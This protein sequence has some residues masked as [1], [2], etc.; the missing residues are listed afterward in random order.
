MPEPGSKPVSLGVLLGEAGEHVV[1]D[2]LPQ[3][4]SRDEAEAR[5]EASGVRRPYC[6]SIV[7]NR[8]LYAALARRLRAAGLLNF[9]G[10]FEQIGRS[11]L[12]LLS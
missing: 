9:H 10:D 11:W 5:K 1:A 6:D 8:R 12:E 4:L 2:L 7:E 3:V